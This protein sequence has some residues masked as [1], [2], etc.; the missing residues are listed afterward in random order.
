MSSRCGKWFRFLRGYVDLLERFPL[1]EHLT[2]HCHVGLPKGNWLVFH[3]LNPTKH[4][5][6]HCSNGDLPWPPNKNVTKSPKNH[7]KITQNHQKLSQIQLK[8]WGLPAMLG[9]QRINP[10]AGLC[11]VYDRWS[12]VD[13]RGGPGNL[14]YPVPPQSYVSPKK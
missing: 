3:P 13:W 8:S 6:D 14:R 4:F 1:R 5:F 7:Q 9:Y 10:V 2:Y 11:F 12:D